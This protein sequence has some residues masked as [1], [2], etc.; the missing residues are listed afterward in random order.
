MD[1]SGGAWGGDGDGG[2]GFGDDAG[3]LGSAYFDVY[4]TNEDCQ[5]DGDCVVSK[6]YPSNY[7]A[8]ESCIVIT[9]QAASIALDGALDIHRGDSLMVNM[10]QIATGIISTHRV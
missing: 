3:N 8:G 2:I 1:E 10:Q 9:L 4:A 7:G 6:N 5:V